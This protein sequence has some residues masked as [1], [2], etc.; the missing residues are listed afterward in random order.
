MAANFSRAPPSTKSVPSPQPNSSKAASMRCHVAALRASAARSGT[1]VNGAAHVRA[2][3]VSA[4]PARLLTGAA[5][6]KGEPRFLD[7]VRMNFEK[8]AKHT[9]LSPGM[10]NQIMACNSVLRVSFPIQRVGLRKRA[11]AQSRAKWACAAFDQLCADAP[12]VCRTTAT[13]RSSG[14][15]VPSTAITG[16]HAKAVSVT[17]TPWTCKRWRPWPR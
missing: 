16:R 12:P 3:R 15:T 7:M 13:S 9:D 6:P 2:G 10:V 17:P 14:R 1:L 4:V 11:G 8:A 5:A